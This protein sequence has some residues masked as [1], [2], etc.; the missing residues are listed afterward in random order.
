MTSRKYRE[1]LEERRRGLRVLGWR[2]LSRNIW[3]NPRTGRQ[4]TL[5]LAIA[6]EEINGNLHNLWAREHAARQRAN[7]IVRR[8]GRPSRSEDQIAA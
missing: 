6:I 1:G 5:V 2:E 4:W 7:G 3:I 8:R